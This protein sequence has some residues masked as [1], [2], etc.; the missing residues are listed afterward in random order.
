MTQGQVR[1]MVRGESVVI[2]VIGALLGAVLG[3]GLG[4]ALTRALYDQGIEIISIPGLQ[5]GLYV[6]AAAAAG[7]LAAIGPA[8]SAARVDVLK[9]VVTD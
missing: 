1:A 8:R 3:I 6:V 5:L 7:V 9:A 4:A 2:S